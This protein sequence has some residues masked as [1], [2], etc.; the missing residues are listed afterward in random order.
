MYILKTVKPL[1]FVGISARHCLAITLC[2]VTSVGRIRAWVCKICSSSE[3]QFNQ[4]QRIWDD[5]AQ[6]GNLQSSSSLSFFL[7]WSCPLLRCSLGGNWLCGASHAHHR[8]HRGAEF[9]WVWAKVTSSTQL[10]MV[11]TDYSKTMVWVQSSTC[12]E[13]VNSYTAAVH[14]GS[15]IFI[16]Y[17][18]FLIAFR[19]Q[20]NFLLKSLCYCCLLIS[21]FLFSFPLLSVFSS[22]I[23]SSLYNSELYHLILSH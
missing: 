8:C 7:L 18:P 17:F 21:L 13:P 3:V 20:I 1:K 23:P 2:A 10:L 22:E 16:H 12:T 9:P 4:L 5:L 14:F 11:L 15:Y 19:L 6:C